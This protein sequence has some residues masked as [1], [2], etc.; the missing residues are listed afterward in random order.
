MIA[1]EEARDMLRDGVVEVDVVVGVDGTVDVRVDAAVKDQDDGAVVVRAVA[2]TL[3]KN[4]IA[5]TPEQV[6]RTGEG[7]GGLLSLLSVRAE[8]TDGNGGR[9]LARKDD[10]SRI[11][12]VFCRGWPGRSIYRRALEQRMEIINPQL[13]P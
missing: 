5:R 7:F 4:L 10:G 6:S 8:C 3:P 2:T 1:L 13:I 11:A 12:L 9:L